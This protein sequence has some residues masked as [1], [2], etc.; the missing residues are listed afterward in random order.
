M[1]RRLRTDHEKRFCGVLRYIDA[2]DSCCCPLITVVLASNCSI[3]VRQDSALAMENDMTCGVIIIRM[4]CTKA[5]TLAAHQHRRKLSEPRCAERSLHSQNP[6]LRV[7]TNGAI[8]Q[9]TRE[10]EAFPNSGLSG[11]ERGGRRLYRFL[12]RTRPKR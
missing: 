5:L 4:R 12:F 7:S 11:T 3:T 2:A 6:C 10:N 8:K 1:E 9:A